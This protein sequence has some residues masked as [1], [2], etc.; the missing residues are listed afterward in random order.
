MYVTVHRGT[1]QIGGLRPVA[2][3]P[4]HCEA[5]NRKEFLSLHG[6]CL[7]LNVGQRWEVE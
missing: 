5:G 7:M 2:L 6:N 4:I 1:Q 3:L